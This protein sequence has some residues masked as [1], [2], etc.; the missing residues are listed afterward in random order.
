MSAVRMLPVKIFIIVMALAATVQAA[1]NNYTIP[2]TRWL[3][4]KSWISGSYK[5]R[6][7]GS[8]NFKTL[9]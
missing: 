2:S 1:P 6:Y 3:S 5:D 7:E 4:N 8:K 9:I